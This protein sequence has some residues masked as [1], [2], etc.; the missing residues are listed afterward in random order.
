MTKF[1]NFTIAET[2]GRTFEVPMEKVQELIKERG[3]EPVDFNDDNEVATILKDEL[4][5]ELASY[6]KDN[7]FV[8]IELCC[9]KFTGE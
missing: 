2:S 7:Q 6:E 4:L 1:L 5:D 8:E 9:S 3:I